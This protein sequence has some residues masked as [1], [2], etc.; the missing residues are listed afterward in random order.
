MK[1][2]PPALFVAVLCAAA[3]A[4]AAGCTRA[5]SDEQAIRA[6]VQRRVQTSSNLKMSAMD[7]QINQVNIQG[8]RAQAQTDFRLKDGGM[9]MQVNYA[10]ERRNGDWVVLRSDPAGGQITHP[11]MDQPPA[12]STS[13]N[14][15]PKF[16]VPSDSPAL[17]PGHPP[18]NTPPK[19]PTKDSSTA[20]RL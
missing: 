15:F 16:H 5:Q 6:A 10:L 18:V 3:A 8:D 14:G 4:L 19:A 9:T 17:P 7:M 20:P 1:M 12:G 11:P 13:A 2:R